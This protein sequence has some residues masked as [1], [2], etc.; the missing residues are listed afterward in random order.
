MNDKPSSPIRFSRRTLLKWSCVTAGG[1]AVASLLP[2]ALFPIS[3]AHA[4]QFTGYRTGAWTPSCCNM[5]GGQCGI[6]VYVEDGIA[7]KIEPQGGGAGL[8]SNPNNIANTSDGYVAALSAGDTGRLCC[9]GNSGLRSLYDPDRLQTPMRRVGPRGSDLFEPITWEQ[10]IEEAARRLSSV[11]SR[12]GAR[13][14]VWFGE[15]HSFTHIQS[16]FC[17]AYGSPNYSNHSNLCDTARKAIWQSTLGHGRPLP[18]MEHADTM[19]VFGWNFLSAIKFIHLPAIFTRARM[20]NPNFHFIYVDPVYNTTASKADQWVA[21]RPGS[22]GALALALCQRIIASGVVSTA[23]MAAYATGYDEFVKYL[24][25]DAAGVYD[26]STVPWAGQDIG[27]WASTITGIALPEIEAIAAR[28]VADKTAGRKICID[29]WSGPGQHSNATQSGRAIGALAILLGIVDMPGGLCFPLRSGTSHRSSAGLGWPS[30]DGWR[31][32]G[33]DNVT[34]PATYTYPDGTSSANPYDGA[35]NKKYAYS[36]GSGIYVEQRQRMIEQT[37]F[38]GNPYPIKAAVFVFQNFMMSTPNTEKNTRALEN[39][40]FVLCVDTHMSETAQMA[41]IVIPGS[42]Y[43]ERNDFNSNWGLFRSIGLRQPVVPSWIGGMSET[44]FFLHLGQALGFGGFRTDATTMSAEAFN[45]DEWTRFVTGGGWGN[46]MTWSD[47][48]AQGTWV[49]TF[50][51]PDGSANPTGTPSNGATTTPKGGTHYRKYKA[52]KTFAAGDTVSAIAVGTQTVY[53]VESSVGVALGIGTG[54]TM[55]VGDSYEVGFGTDSRRL[56]FWD[57]RFA[58]YFAGTTQRGDRGGN[59]SVAGDVRY[60][61]LP[62]NVLPEDAP[63]T[64]GSGDFPLYFISWKEVEHTHTRTFN[65]P[66][67]MEMRGENRL[68]IHPTVATPAG[69]FENDSVFVQ[70]EY[71]TIKVRAHVTTGIQRETVGFAR[72]FGHWALGSL[73][74]GKG[75]H[76][77]WLLPGKAELHSGQA[78]HKEVACR[79][80]KEV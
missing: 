16:D 72:G 14:L 26:Y 27:T 51:N 69:I 32:D 62:Y 74:K 40:E 35:L 5:C 2:S 8:V 30:A 23:D 34:I 3:R 10:A 39:M 15:D 6:Q 42:I 64:P 17:K 33:R 75:A 76:D 56:Q 21:P 77:G 29:A 46:T 49:E 24:N 73:A 1:A 13:S 53:V 38:V 67:L 4:A 58:G 63:A 47:I 41:D 61:P 12:Y 7:R 50:T 71:G 66:Y 48:R 31:V 43:L 57:P 44:D 79:I 54:P 19:L 80:Y 59:Q 70:T 45:A 37:D 60:H 55:A 65:N 22:D 36:H 20:N 18:D 11:R 9:K 25:A 68:F 28:L 52:R 78:I